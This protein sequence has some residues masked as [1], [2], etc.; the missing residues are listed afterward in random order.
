MIVSVDTA[1][2]GMSV[3][4]AFGKSLTPVTFPL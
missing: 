4:T 3:I 2:L 1:D